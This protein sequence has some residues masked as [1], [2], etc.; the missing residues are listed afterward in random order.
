M[1]LLAEWYFHYHPSERPIPPPAKRGRAIEV[2]PSIFADDSEVAYAVSILVVVNLDGRGPH[3]RAAIHENVLARL[4]A[5]DHADLDSIT[6]IEPRDAVH[7][8]DL[9]D[10]GQ[11]RGP[12]PILHCPDCHAEASANRADYWLARPD[13]VMLCTGPEEDSHPPT[14]MQLVLRRVMIEGWPVIR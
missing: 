2:E 12:R 4:Q 11:L 9:P 7:V 14:S 6:R 1:H 5:G 10:F 3:S 8:R 13:T